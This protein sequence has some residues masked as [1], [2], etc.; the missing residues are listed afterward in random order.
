VPA[1]A[2]MTWACP[3]PHTVL[4][5]SVAFDYNNIPL[6]SGRALTSREQFALLQEALDTA[7][8][9]QREIGLN[10]EGF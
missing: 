7:V 5:A 10:I 2:G 4:A 6:T 1:Q 3:Q 9:K 8:R